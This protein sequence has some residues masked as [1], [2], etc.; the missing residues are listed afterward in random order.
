[1]PAYPWDPLMRAA[2]LG[3]L[4]RKAQARAAFAEL[5]SLRPEFPEDPRLLHHV[6]LIDGFG[7]QVLDGLRK[8]GLEITRPRTGEQ[9][10]SANLT[11]AG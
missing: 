9:T 6:D 5:L 1:M 7:D 11:N 8:A 2:C 10:R 4:G 3:Q